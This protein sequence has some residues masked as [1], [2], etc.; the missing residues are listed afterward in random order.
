MRKFAQSEVR[1]NDD[2]PN[3]ADTRW[4]RTLDFL[5]IGIVILV[6][7]IASASKL[8]LIAKSSFGAMSLLW[9][10]LAT[11]ECSI[12]YS[13]FSHPR[14]RTTRILAISL[15]AMFG[16]VSIGFALSG[17][18]TCSCMGIV[19]TSPVAMAT[20]D[21]LLC[22]LLSVTL[23][24]VSTSLNRDISSSFRRS[25]ITFGVAGSLNLALC[26]LLST[27]SFPSI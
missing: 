8:A 17:Y 2:E 24:L 18:R 14:S 27:I 25:V 3:N 15:F 20:L 9:F 21:I 4:L 23:V 7:C 19:R 11:V 22:F 26:I 16:V 1:R 10:A 6:L 13:L 12:A 5:I